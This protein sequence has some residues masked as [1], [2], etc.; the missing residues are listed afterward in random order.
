MNS[1]T[2]NKSAFY[3]KGVLPLSV[4]AFLGFIGLSLV[5][6]SLGSLLYNKYPKTAN[7]QQ[8]AMQTAADFTIAL[9]G[10]DYYAAHAFLSPVTQKHMATANDLGANCPG[11]RPLSGTWTRYDPEKRTAY[12]T[13]FFETADGDT[14]ELS[15]EVK[16]VW[17]K[18]EFR[19]VGAE[20]GNDDISRMSF[21]FCCDDRHYFDWTYF[22]TNRLSENLVSF[23]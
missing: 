15:T 8:E 22:V 11:C 1:Q 14:I 16:L 13:A 5:A 3:E 7:G 4:R 20:F 6:M 23:H 19:I 17:L 18:G 9:A 2:S 21:L 10:R 12:G